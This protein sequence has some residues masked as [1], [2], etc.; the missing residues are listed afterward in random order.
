MDLSKA[1]DEELLDLYFAG[2]AAAFQAFFQ[3]HKA[4]VFGYARRKGLDEAAAQDVS[5]EAFLKLHRQI[6]HYAS[7]RPALPWFFT[8]VHHCVV[9]AKRSSSRFTTVELDQENLPSAETPDPSP[10]AL[11]QLLA[12]LSA[13]QKQLML[14]R[15]VEELSFKDIA[16]ATGKKD[17]SLRK[18]YERTR[19]HLRQRLQ[20]QRR[21]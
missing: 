18:I 14:M 20:K 21:D 5:Q 8:I 1:S 9:D 19:S 12:G 4:R 13:D 15:A 6:H 2:D 17:F 3:R 16:A 10:A 7:G 11:D